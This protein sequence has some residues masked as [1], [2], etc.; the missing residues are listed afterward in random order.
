[1]GRVAAFLGA[2]RRAARAPALRAHGLAGGEGAGAKQAGVV[3][4]SRWGFSRQATTGGFG[5]A[6]T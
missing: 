5:E 6:E 2:A 1:M 3:T 4:R